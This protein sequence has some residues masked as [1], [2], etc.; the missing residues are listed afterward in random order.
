MALP[1]TPSPFLQLS[2]SKPGT[3]LWAPT[4]VH[5]LFYIST[6]CIQGKTLCVSSLSPCFS[7]SHLLLCSSCVPLSLE[8]SPK[9]QGL[10]IGSKH[11]QVFAYKVLANPT[12]TH[13]HTHTH[14][15]YSSLQMLSS[16]YAIVMQVGRAVI[17]PP[18]KTASDL[19]SAKELVTAIHQ[20]Q[21]KVMDIHAREGMSAKLARSL[22][23][24]ALPLHMLWAPT[25]HQALMHQELDGSQLCRPLLAPRL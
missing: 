23:D 6:L 8:H 11:P 9:L 24:L 13:T 2:L 5:M 25:P 7:L 14:T 17:N 19:P 12:P 1:L 3:L 15:F 10:C 20:Q 22:G 21:L 4:L 18:S 16:P